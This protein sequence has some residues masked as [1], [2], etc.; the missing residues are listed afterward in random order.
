MKLI[1]FLCLF[2]FALS[3]FVAKEQKGDIDFYLEYSTSTKTIIIKGT[4]VTVFEWIEDYDNSSSLRPGARKE[5]IKT[6]SISI[7]E[8]NEVRD[9]VK[10]SGFMKLP[11]DEYGGKGESTYIPIIISIKMKRKQKG[12]IF[13]NDSNSSSESMPKAFSELEKEVNR[14]IDSLKEWK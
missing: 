13:K 2:F 7:V 14:L 4:M 10:S 9:F 1:I 3:S 11:K 12:I 5:I 8:L 6:S